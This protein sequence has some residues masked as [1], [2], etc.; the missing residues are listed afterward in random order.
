MSFREPWAR[1]KSINLIRVRQ[2]VLACVFSAVTAGIIAKFIPIDM[3]QAP[4]ADMNER[5]RKSVKHSLLSPPKKHALEK[6]LWYMIVLWIE[7]G[8]LGKDECFFPVNLLETLYHI[9]Y[10][11]VCKKT[12]TPLEIPHAWSCLWILLY[13]Q[14]GAFL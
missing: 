3:S 14:A 1:K 6:E 8:K 2:L 5:P 11:L 4:L 13:M 7:T 12:P 9:S 10:I